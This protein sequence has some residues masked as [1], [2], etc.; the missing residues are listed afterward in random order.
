[1]VR[2][3]FRK[4][5]PK[6]QTEVEIES[7]CC[8]NCCWKSQS[9]H[10]PQINPQKC[11]A[12]VQVALAE[13]VYDIIS[14]LARRNIQFGSTDLSKLSAIID[15]VEF[16]NFMEELM[17]FVK[18]LPPLQNTA[19]EINVK[20]KRRIHDKIFYLGDEILTAIAYH[21]T[22][23]ALTMNIRATIESTSASIAEEDK[24]E[25]ESDERDSVFP[26]LSK[27]INLLLHK[28][29]SYLLIESQF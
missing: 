27:I 26:L 4:C 21:T 10:G 9:D 14:N 13:T 25:P 6:K 28:L 3:L 23:Q 1:M 17:K 8:W 16:Q 19:K 29:C 18:K 20:L 7:N 22:D 5:C 12:L 11:S 15:S 24:K 2:P